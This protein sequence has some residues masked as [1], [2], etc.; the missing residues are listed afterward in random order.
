MSTNSRKLHGKIALITGGSTGLGL[1]AALLFV[2]EGAYVFI[3][4]RR[5]AELNAAAKQIGSN[6]T[7]VQETPQIRATLIDSSRLSKRRRGGST[8][9][10]PTL[11]E[12]NSLRLAQ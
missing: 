10:L 6:V 9:S 11:V 1:A 3:T 12:H 7:A 5:K 8:F 2:A 4:G